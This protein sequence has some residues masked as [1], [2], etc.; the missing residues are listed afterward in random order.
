MKLTA[1]V[2]VGILLIVTGFLYDIIFAGIPYQEPTPIM[3]QEYNYHQYIA[4]SIKRL[5]LIVVIIGIFKITQ[6]RISKK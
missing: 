3:T 2:V 6:K 4:N 5:G 1:V